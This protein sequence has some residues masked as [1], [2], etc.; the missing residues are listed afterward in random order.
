MSTSET[1]RPPF[2]PFDTESAAKKV[3]MAE[4][5]WNTREPDRVALA[6]TP[7][8]ILSVNGTRS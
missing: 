1:P 7:D 6:Y 2:P 4:D 3:R 5:A 8:S